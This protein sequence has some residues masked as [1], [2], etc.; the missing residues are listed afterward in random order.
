MLII[1]TLQ[2]VNF[3][4]QNVHLATQRTVCDFHYAQE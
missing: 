2:A 4:L 3:Y 1:D